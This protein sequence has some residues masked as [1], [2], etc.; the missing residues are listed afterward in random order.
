MKSN[1]KMYVD[2][3]RKVCEYTMYAICHNN[4]S[5][6]VYGEGG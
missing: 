2:Y 4:P 6:L 1:S 5:L 3:L